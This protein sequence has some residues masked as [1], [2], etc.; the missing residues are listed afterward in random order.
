MKQSLD[1]TH[2][3]FLSQINW[4]GSLGRKQCMDLDFAKEIIFWCFEVQDVWASLCGA[5][6]FPFPIRSK[7][8]INAGTTEFTRDF[9]LVVWPTGLVHFG[10]WRRFLKRFE[11]GETDRENILGT[12]RRSFKAPKEQTHSVWVYSSSMLP[13]NYPF[14]VPKKV[15]DYGF[16][17]LMAIL[18]FYCFLFSFWLLRKEKSSS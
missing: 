17:T 18:C 7:Q 12:V 11:W 14:G 10:F 2:L 5:R 3:L 16:D 9:S 8:T 4:L 13:I 15:A 6:L 1:E